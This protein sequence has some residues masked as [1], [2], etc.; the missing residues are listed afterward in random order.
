M[1]VDPA[2]LMVIGGVVSGA[3]QIATATASANAAK[4][5]AAVERQNAQLADRQA[6]N[7]LEAGLK[8]EQKQKAMTGQLIAKQQATQ[9]ANGVDVTFGTPLDIMIDAAKMGAVDAATLR[10]NSYLK[11]DDV[12]NE[13]VNHRNQASLYNMQA[14]NAMLSGVIGAGSSVLGGFT[15]AAKYKAQMKAGG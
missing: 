7:T 13:A 3:G 14:S 10:R 8:E 5:S 11:Y 12:R 4:Y 6:K 15:D 2:T 9:A 1:C